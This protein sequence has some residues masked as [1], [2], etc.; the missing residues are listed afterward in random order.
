M[1]AVSDLVAGPG[2]L[3]LKAGL[4]GADL[5]VHLVLLHR[6]EHLHLQAAPDTVNSN[7]IG[8]RPMSSQAQTGQQRGL[9]LCFCVCPR[10]DVLVEPPDGLLER[11]LALVRVELLI[12][13][14]H[15]QQSITMAAAS[16]G[17]GLLSSVRPPEK[18]T[19]GRLPL[20]CLEHEYEVPGVSV[21]LDERVEVESDLLVLL[22]ALGLVQQPLHTATH[23]HGP[24]SGCASRSGQPCVF[25]SQ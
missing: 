25:R 5:D 18:A 6:E 8:A 9:N 23:E 3:E 7:T 17:V 14:E 19:L 22:V 20:T 15:L 24:S 11:V 13:L 1:L 16:L 12:L 21:V 2:G 10:V 4:G